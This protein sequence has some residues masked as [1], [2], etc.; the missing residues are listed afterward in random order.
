MTPGLHSWPAPPQ[1]LTLIMSPRLGFR[2]KGEMGKN[3]PHLY[4][5]DQPNC[6]HK[7]SCCLPNATLVLT[8]RFVCYVAVFHWI[9]KTNYC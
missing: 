4:S 5:M 8:Y 2:Q 6:L 9:P 7:E 1:A 3:V